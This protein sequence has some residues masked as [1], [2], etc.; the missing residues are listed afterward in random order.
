[1]NRIEAI[2]TRAYVRWRKQILGDPGR[3]RLE[4]FWSQLSALEREAVFVANLNY[5][6]ENGG[7]FQW[8]DNGYAAPRV[9]ADL[10]CLCL[11][12]GALEVH[13]LLEAFLSAKDDRGR[14]LRAG[15]CKEVVWEDYAR[16]LDELSDRYYEVGDQF[17]Q[18]VED[19][20][21]RQETARVAVRS[22]V[23]KEA[24]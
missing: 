14:R 8:E 13:R 19:D 24:A 12:L 9:V 6:V 20:L 16:T 2:T 3:E 23:A 7:F 1:M 21:R 18:D 4:V 5:Q 17:L 22:V 10:L 15:A 11:R